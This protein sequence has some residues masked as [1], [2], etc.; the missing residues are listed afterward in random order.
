[1]L[2][3]ANV[4]LYWGRQTVY[5]RTA[6]NAGTALAT[7]VTALGRHVV[8]DKA[9]L[10][11]AGIANGDRV[12]IDDGLSTEEYLT[13]GRIQTTDDVTGADLGTSDRVWFT[14]P[15]RFAHAAGAAFQE[16]TLSTRA[17]GIAYDVTDAATGTLTLVAGR[18]TAG[19]PVVV[20]Y[21][22]HG[23]F[24]WYRAPGDAQQALFPAPIADT[25]EL[26]ASWGDWKGLPLVDGTYTVGM[27]ANIDFT[28]GPDRALRPV[29]AWNNLNTD[30]TTYRS[31]S[32]P[33]TKQ[34]LFGTATVPTPRNKVASGATCNRC[35]TEVLAHG[36]GR[37]GLDT[38]LLCHT[39]PGVEDG[40]KYT[41]AS[42]YVG[43]TSGVTM[44]F[45]S[46]L[47]KVHMGSQ[48]THADTYTVNGVFLGTPYPVKVPEVGEVGGAVRCEGCHGQ[49]N[50]AWKQPATPSH[51][52]QPTGVQSWQLACSSCHDSDLATVHMTLMTA[53][54]GL[55]SC[56]V[57]HGPGR[58]SAVDVVHVAR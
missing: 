56:S 5:E 50:T 55:E 30:N 39:T 41:Y 44:D 11:A 10:D 12:V 40:P 53:P 29:G 54:A 15:L 38:C 14:T 24:G 25:D 13:I 4:P 47:H 8:V 28:V 43:P 31:M 2:Q 1:V 42:W 22:T 52:M 49:G 17:E 58:D 27:W 33:A 57:C 48:L 9:A 32:P 16:V 23:R 46:L 20:S 6:L 26:D 36:F 45:R 21:R 34:F 19:N 37:R 35:H 51:P 3:V 18:F 7:G